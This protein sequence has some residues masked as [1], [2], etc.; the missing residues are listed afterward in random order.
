MRDEVECGGEKGAT[1]RSRA[2]LLSR[3]Y[4]TARLSTP[5][6][7]FLFRSPQ[8]VED[9]AFPLLSRPY[10]FSRSRIQMFRNLTGCS[11]SWSPSG[12]RSGPA[13]YGGRRPF[14]VGPTGSTSSCTSTP[15]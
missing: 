9:P 10:L 14:A 7:A 2:L 5:H 13:S 6:P 4:L 11:W 1:F 12:S 3:R 8:R 15:L